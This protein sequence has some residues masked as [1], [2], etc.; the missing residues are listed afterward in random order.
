MR[1]RRSGDSSDQAGNAA[2]AAATASL[3]VI[4]EASATC[5]WTWPSAGLNTS[6]WR[7]PSN[8]TTSPS[9]KC[10]IRPDVSCWVEL[11]LMYSP[12]SCGLGPI[13]GARLN[14]EVRQRLPYKKT[15]RSRTL[16]YQYIS[17]KTYRYKPP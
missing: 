9:M 13:D 4:A 11:L 7:S 10:P 16:I 1:E 5:A 2:R 8:E 14:A 17:Y 6:A 12:I 15:N 3:T